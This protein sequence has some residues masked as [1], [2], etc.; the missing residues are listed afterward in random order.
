MRKPFIIF[1]P[2]GVLCHSKHIPQ[3]ASRGSFRSLQEMD[4][5][6]Q[7]D[8]FINK[9]AIRARPGLRPFLREV[10]GLAHVIIW[11]CMLMDN[12]KAITCFLFQELAMPCL[13]LGQEHCDELY[14]HSGKIIPNVTGGGGPQFLKIL[15]KNLWVGVPMLEGVPHG[16][17]P[18]PENTLL[19]DDSEYPQPP[20]QRHL[21]ASL[22]MR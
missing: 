9:K 19:V 13:L 17:W 6:G 7:F 11:S 1:D 18:T 20:G 21:P 15:M 5:D 10:L 22:K 16:C 4:Y 12:T 14:D 8:I 2:N 3:S